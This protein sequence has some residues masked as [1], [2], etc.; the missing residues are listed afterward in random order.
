M[1]S[2]V[3]IAEV[4]LLRASV[5]VREGSTSGKVR[6]AEPGDEPIG[7]NLETARANRPV[8]VRLLDG[9]P[10]P[11]AAGET[12]VER[13]SLQIG[14]GGTVVRWTDGMR[15]GH[16]LTSGRPPQTIIFVWQK[17]EPGWSIGLG[18]PE[19]VVTGYAVGQG[20]A[21]RNAEGNLVNIWVYAGVPGQ[22][23]G[24]RTFQ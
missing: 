8:T 4:D 13:D 22:K 6:P 11:V 24:W 3:Y 17:F 21:E 7:L 9:L 10:V 5:L 14:P 15:I 2:I 20:Y 16:A 19:G 12:I 23:T 1:A 18:S